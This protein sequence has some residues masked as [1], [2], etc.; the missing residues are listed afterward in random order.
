MPRLRR[1][2]RMTAMPRL[3][4]KVRMTASLLCIPVF[5]G[6]NPTGIG[7]PGL[8]NQKARR[9]ILLSR[10]QPSLTRWLGPRTQV[11][12]PGT[13]ESF[14]TAVLDDFPGTQDSAGPAGWLRP[15]TQ[16]LARSKPST[17][18]PGPRTQAFEPG[19]GNLGSGRPTRAG[20]DPGLGVWHAR[21]GTRDPGPR[22]QAFEPG[23]WILGFPVSLVGRPGPG[24]RGQAHYARH[25]GPGTQDPGFQAWVQEPSTR[26]A[27]VSFPRPGTRSASQ[28]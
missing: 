13:R 15:G 20:R 8:G 11:F 9:C 5:R 10:S 14:G 28:G 12:G 4:R 21:P 17:R 1:K 3:R 25:P 16:D 7:H 6:R 2:V 27:R 19:S 26:L 18:D 22:T 23:S 24:T